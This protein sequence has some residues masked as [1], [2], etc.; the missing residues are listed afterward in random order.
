MLFILRKLGETLM[1]KLCYVFIVLLSFCLVISGC[2]LKN[3]NE[4]LEKDKDSPLNLKV[5]IPK[6]SYKVVFDG[7]DLVPNI[8][9]I[10]GNGTKYQTAGFS[11]RG[12]FVN[13]YALEDGKI[14]CIKEYNELPSEQEEH[15]DE[16][17]FLDK[18]EKGDKTVMLWEPLETKSKEGN[19]EIV[20][21]GK[22]LKL[23][24]LQL[25][26]HYIKVEEVN[27]GINADDKTIVT[28]YYSEGLG[29]VKYV[30]TM[31][32]VDVCFSVL[33]DYMKIK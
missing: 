6:E 3:D 12:S 33:K 25:K 23:D 21:I 10:K 28:S 2:S 15:L 1:K 5:F 30:V 4:I 19:N 26:G 7:T 13:V 11:G 9:Y 24:K 16:V 29:R 32:G 8:Q 14:N 27:E 22:D 17:N 31:D 18:D 20:E